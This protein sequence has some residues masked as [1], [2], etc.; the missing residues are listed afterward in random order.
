MKQY[1]LPFVLLCM[2]ATAFAHPGHDAAGFVGGFFHPFSGLDHML[3]LL[4]LGIWA[5]MRQRPVLLSACI[6]LGGMLGGGL[7][8]AQ[9]PLPALLESLVLGTAFLAAL[10]VALAV[11]LPLHAE[12]LVSALFA[13]IHGMAHGAEMPGGVALPAYAAGFLLA[14]ALLLLAGWAGAALLGRQRRQQWLGAGLASVA[15]LML[16]AAW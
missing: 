7:L 3:A 6:I 12:W 5:A 1:I 2:P 14:S 4:A 11:R 10:L 8:G 9:M 13:A 15:G 16:F